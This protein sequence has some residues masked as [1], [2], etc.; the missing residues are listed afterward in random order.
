MAN[1]PNRMTRR[2]AITVAAYIER[3]GNWP[4]EARLSPES[5]YWVART[6]DLDHFA[7]LAERLKLRVTKHSDIAVG[8]KAGHLVYPP[9]A[10][11]HPHESSIDR[12]EDELGSRTSSSTRHRSRWSTLPPRSTARRCSTS[13]PSKSC[14]P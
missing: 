3:H 4:T 6:L 10:D 7:R 13:S 9:A 14:S 5:L 12:V 2:L 11:D 1:A 8:G